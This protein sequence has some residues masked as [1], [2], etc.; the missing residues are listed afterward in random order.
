MDIRQ[1]PDGSVTWY[2]DQEGLDLGRAGGPKTPTAATQA[3]YRLATVAVVP[4]GIAAGNGGVV[5]WQPD[6]NGI[7]YIIS[8]VD[9]DIT[10]A[11]SGQT[12]N[13]GTAANG[14][15][16]SANLLDTL[17]IAATGTFDN[18]TDKGT[19]GKSRQHLTAGQFI[20]ATA[21][22]TPASLAGN[23]YITYWPV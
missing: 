16:S 11:Q 5:S 8:A 15:T 1:R 6:N 13:I 17:S 22:G 2:S 4:L 23:L 19:N 20:T 9:L 21:S 3:K 7:D 10:S 12:V 14:S 18:T